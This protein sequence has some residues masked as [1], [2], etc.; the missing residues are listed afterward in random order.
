MFYKTV[1]CPNSRLFLELKTFPL[2]IE[3]YSNVQT[4]IAQFQPYSH[5]AHHYLLTQNHKPFV[6]AHQYISTPFQ[7]YLT[8]SISLS[9][10]SVKLKKKP[11][12]DYKYL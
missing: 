8:M 3:F 1:S 9:S 4:F 11:P 10:S 2:F 12:L 6:L 5:V 7:K